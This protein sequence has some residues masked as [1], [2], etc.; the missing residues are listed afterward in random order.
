MEVGVVGRRRAGRGEVEHAQL[1]QPAAAGEHAD[2]AAGGGRHGRDDDVVVGAVAAV[3]DRLGVSTCGRAGR[4][5]RQER[6]ARVVGDL[7]WGAGRGDGGAG[8]LEQ[9][10]AAR[11]AVGLG[12]LGQLVG[13]D[14]PEQRLVGQDRLE[15]LDLA[16]QRLLL[17]LELDPAEPGQP[18]AAAC[19]GCSWPA[20]RRGRRPT[21]AARGRSRRSSLVRI[22]WMTSSM[23]SSATQQAVDEVQP[24]GLLVA[25]ERASG[26][27]RR[28]S[29]APGRPRA[30][31]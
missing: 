8:R 16:A 20:P 22:T 30:A 5:G 3:A 29:G 11:G 7:E 10:G 4:T 27:V 12:D 21:S 6:E 25:A 18:A 23:S 17:L 31:P 15:L 24:L 13:D 19:R 26:G 14:L 28:R 2:L 1:E 9:D